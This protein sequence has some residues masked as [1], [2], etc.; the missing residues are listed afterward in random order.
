MHNLLL[1]SQFVACLLVFGSHHVGYDIKPNAMLL[2]DMQKLAI[3]CELMDKREYNEIFFRLEDFVQDARCIRERKE[4][5]RNAP[6]A[7]DSYLFPDRDLISKCME[8][9]FYYQQFLKSNR[10]LNS[11]TAVQYSKALVQCQT[12]RTLYDS[13]RD[14]KTD[15]MYI[16]IRRLALAKIRQTIGDE[17]YY[18]GTLPPALPTWFFR[19]N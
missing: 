2:Q 1:E 10:Y 12:L 15:Y 13:V 7:S 17:A 14:A 19:E 6:A 8:A 11:S 3:V 18:T 9:N 16:T 4:K 5:L